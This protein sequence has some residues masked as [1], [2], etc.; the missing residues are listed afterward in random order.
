LLGMAR[1]PGKRIVYI[2]KQYGTNNPKFFS[3]YAGTHDP[4]VDLPFLGKTHGAMTHILMDLAVDMAFQLENEPMTS[5]DFRAMLKR[6]TGFVNEETAQVVPE[7]AEDAVPV[8]QMVWEATY[9][10]L[11]TD[12]LNTPED[13]ARKLKKLFGLM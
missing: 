12:Q 4:F 8:G 7:G 6:C 3:D 1:K 2:P 11:E 10:L 13:M 5:G 9:D